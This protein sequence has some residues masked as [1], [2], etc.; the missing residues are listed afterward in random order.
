MA[1]EVRVKVIL[2]DDGTMRL[3]EKSAKKLGLQLDDLGKNTV[4]VD[5]GLKG[6]AQAGANGTKNFSKMAGTLNG[7]LVPAYATVAA[8]VFAATAVFNNFQ[9]AA[10]T[11]NLAKGLDALGAS[12][13]RNLSKL[14][15][16]LR[17]AT[18]GAI[19]LEQSLRSTALASAGG[20]SGEEFVR[21]GRVARN[22]SVALGR[23]LTDSLDR[24]TR[25]V[26]KLEP[27]ILDELG[28]IVRVD[29]A[30]QKYAA[31]IG[32]SASQLTNLQ[33][34]QAFL[35]ETL[36]QGEQKFDAIGEI[37][38]VDG[39]TKLSATIQDATKTFTSFVNVL[40]E[41][42]A[43][44]FADLPGILLAFGATFASVVLKTVVPALGNIAEESA[45]AAKKASNNFKDLEEEQEKIFGKKNKKRFKELEDVLQSQNKQLS[46]G[47]E[48][49]KKT[50]DLD[51]ARL[52]VYD[53]LVSRQKI[54]VDGKVAGRN[55][56]AQG[57]KD[58]ELTIAVQERL[59]TQLDQ[60]IIK[61]DR[62]AVLSGRALA[63][64]NAASA[65]ATIITGLDDPTI[66]KGEKLRNT[67]DG[68]KK[69]GNDT[70]N[71]L[72]ESTQKTRKGL[73]TA[74]LA[75]I[76]L[77]TSFTVLSASGKVLGS[78]F[79]RLLPYVG[80]IL[81]AIQILAPVVKKVAEAT[82]LWSS[83]ASKLNDEIE[84]QIENSRKQ[85]KAAS[86]QIKVQ[87]K[88]IESLKKE[89][90]TLENLI[91]IKAVESEINKIQTANN[92]AQ[93]ESLAV[94]QAK[95]K[96]YEESAKFVQKAWDFVTGGS[97]AQDAVGEGI[98]DQVARAGDE[99]ALKFIESIRNQFKQNNIKLDGLLGAEELLSSV[100]GAQD[101]ADKSEEILSL[102][103]LLRNEEI[104]RAHV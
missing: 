4:K 56:T 59:L 61:R 67:I 42:L 75:A 15:K 80:P 28:I 24:L 94:L 62:L 96:E 16:D 89:E 36:A 17:D 45:N 25:G 18:Q 99:S 3:T 40:A 83:E 93:A 84:E 20:V 53:S 5:R 8:T 35:N 65:T 6:V 66:A 64:A 70:F 29:E 1:N 86:D 58:L 50:K 82:K 77:R 48:A 33:K 73:T 60:E 32:K 44:V 55:I 68:L 95:A 9:R 74:N 27:E 81:L 91:R 39:F 46:K 30:S 34:R 31:S 78:V 57:R 92:L 76:Q 90:Q 23:D 79:L 104:G 98:I 43:A 72:T 37:I 13:G 54:L 85:E 41:P 52:S 14:A 71:T 11:D 47:L 49:A 101:L 38:P 69:I 10:Q 19:S 26:T 21:L 88:I 100:K 2:D 103:K 12:S 7:V 102:T 22:A 97:A 51:Q 87:Q 63:Q